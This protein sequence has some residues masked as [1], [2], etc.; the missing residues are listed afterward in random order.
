M[1][2]VFLFAFSPFLTGFR[3]KSLFLGHNQRG[4][5]KFCPFF[6][7]VKNFVLFCLSFVLF[8]L[9]F[10]RNKTKKRG[11]F[12]S[13]KNS[14]LFFDTL[15]TK[16]KRKKK[17]ILTTKEEA[18]AFSESALKVFFFSRGQNFV[19]SRVKRFFLFLLLFFYIA[20]SS[21]L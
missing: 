21:I 18:S 2:F 10:L 5:S 15:H 12:E 1:S 17:F 19:L 4:K 8:S 20:N 3:Q 11:E 13:R 6:K 16:E 14:V 7:S 9:C